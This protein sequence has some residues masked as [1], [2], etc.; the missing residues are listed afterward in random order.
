[1][2]EKGKGEGKGKGKGTAKVAPSTAATDAAA[3]AAAGGTTVAVP[4][5]AVFDAINR[6]LT[7]PAASAPDTTKKVSI[8]SV[9]DDLLGGC[10]GALALRFE[11]IDAV[12]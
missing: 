8:D 10:M 1:M 12:Q 4:S 3:A 2:D 7:A 5:T 6:P 9:N 11:T